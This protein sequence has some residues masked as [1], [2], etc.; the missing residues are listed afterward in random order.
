MTT[1][2]L[3]IFICSLDSSLWQTYNGKFSADN[4]IDPMSY[5]NKKLTHTHTRIFKNRTHTRTHIKID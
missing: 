4:N 5:Y 3:A 1:S 2:L